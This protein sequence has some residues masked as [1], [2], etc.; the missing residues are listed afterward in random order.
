[1]TFGPPQGPD[2]SAQNL[3]WINPA[4]PIAESRRATVNRYFEK[5]WYGT[6]TRQVSNR[7]VVMLRDCYRRFSCIAGVDLVLRCSPIGT[8]RREEIGHCVMRTNPLDARLGD[9]F[10]I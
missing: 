1:M 7:A 4:A 9:N 3:Q 8:T 10:R 2:E 5:F 6:P